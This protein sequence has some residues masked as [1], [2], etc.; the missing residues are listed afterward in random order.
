MEGFSEGFWEGL[1]FPPSHY[2]IKGFSKC[3]SSKN[4][5]Q[6]ISSKSSSKSSSRGFFSKSSTQGFS[7]QSS[8]KRPSQGVF[9]KSSSQGVFSKSSS[10]AFLKKEFFKEF[11]SRV[12][13]KEFFSW[14]FSKSSCPRT[15]KEVSK[16]LGGLLKYKVKYIQPKVTRRGSWRAS[17][18]G[19]LPASRAHCPR[20]EGGDAGRSEPQCP[21][22]RGGAR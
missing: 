12:F 11:F 7:S 13:L 20:P 1:L 4:F 9:S 22:R 2:E 10:R 3:S 21:E 15:I 18:R 19:A 6:G 8:S 17:G 14:V 16:L 5:T